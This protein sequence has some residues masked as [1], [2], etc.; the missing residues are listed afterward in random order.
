MIIE[1]NG[2]VPNED[3]SGSI[4]SRIGFLDVKGADKGPLNSPNKSN[5]LST[6]E[7]LERYNDNI[8]I[9]KT[10]FGFTPSKLYFDDNSEKKVETIVAEEI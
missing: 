1:D 10:Q 4:S 6:D 3:N 7:I 5:V 2:T 8:N 9:L